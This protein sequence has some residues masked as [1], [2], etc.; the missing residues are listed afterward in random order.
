M[1]EHS[2][3]H[4][5][6]E[7]QGRGS[8]RH[9]LC[10]RT[11]SISTAVYF[12]LIDTIVSNSQNMHLALK[13]RSFPLV[14]LR[15][16]CPEEGIVDL[17]LWISADRLR[18]YRSTVAPLA[19]P[20]NSHLSNANTASLLSPF[21]IRSIFRRSSDSRKQPYRSKAC[22]APCILIIV[23]AI[24]SSFLRH[25]FLTMVI[26]QPRET[27]IIRTVVGNIKLFDPL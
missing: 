27:P 21:Q 5:I 20:F 12:W 4:L 8:A 9:V 6:I 18:S 23:S 2:S 26:Q 17:N 1:C 25:D 10:Q 22:L 7:N 13:Q 16:Y 11:H 24:L 15:Y 14:C 3:C 19:R